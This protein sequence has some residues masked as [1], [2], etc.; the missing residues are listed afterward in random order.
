MSELGVRS[1]LFADDGKC[2]LELGPNSD[3]VLQAAINAGLAHLQSLQLGFSL[4]KC[5]VLHFGNRN[6]RHELLVNGAVIKAV[7]HERDL[8]VIID[9]E[10]KFS[11]HCATVV[12][13]A[14]CVMHLIRRSFEIRDRRFLVDMFCKYVV[15]IVMYAS[16]VWSPYL[17]KDVDAVERVQCWWTKRLPGLYNLSYAERLK[18]LGLES[19]ELMRVKADLVFAY[20]VFNGL[21]A[22]S[23]GSSSFPLVRNLEAS[24]LASTRG[25][26]HKLVKL[27]ARLNC[28]RNFFTVR[29]FD[30]WNSLQ[31]DFA[32]APSLAVFRNKLC[33][34][35]RDIFNNNRCWKDFLKGRALKQ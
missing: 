25:N 13:R 10:L 11:V 21:I 9:R 3:G 14:F 16:P 15:P 33:L 20:K 34:D 28:R 7:N 18:V 29:I 32:N 19:L 27:P 24:V 26:G 5:S 1:K 35:G 17:L 4:P 23:K 30:V 6:P 22:I 2:Y 12:K 8:G 31:A